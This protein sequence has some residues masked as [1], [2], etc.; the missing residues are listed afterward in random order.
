MLQK[1][2]AVRRAVF[3]FANHADELRVQA[4][5]SEVD[6]RALSCFDYFFFHLFAHLCHNFFDACRVNAAVDY[7]LMKGEACYFAAHRVES[8]KHDSLRG[9]V[10]DNLY[11]GGSLKG[12]VCFCL[13]GL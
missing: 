3:H 5:Y 8:G 7:E 9:V 4:M 11:A 6:C 10:Y 12:R 1:V 13:R 2:L